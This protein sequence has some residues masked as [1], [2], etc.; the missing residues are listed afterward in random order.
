MTPLVGPTVAMFPH[1]ERLV[2]DLSQLQEHVLSGRAEDDMTP[3]KIEKMAF[4]A[5]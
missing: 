2:P 1:R 3:K 4:F 5:F